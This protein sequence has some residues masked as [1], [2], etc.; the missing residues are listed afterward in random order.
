MPTSTPEPT[1]GPFRER[2]EA[3]YDRHG[4]WLPPLFFVAGFTWDSLTLRRIDAWVDNV[5]L[6]AYLIALGLMIT[7]T[8]MT[9]CGH[10][11]RAFIVKYKR[12]HPLAIQFFLGGLF[13]AYVVFYFKSASAMESYVFLSLLVLLLIANEFLERRLNTIELLLP[14][15]FLACSSFLTFFIPV[16]TKQVA[17]W[18]FVLANAVSLGIVL[19]MVVYFGKRSVF[20]SRKHF[21]AAGGIIL[22][23]YA[24]MH[25][26]YFKN[27][28]P[29]VPLA[30]TNAGVYHHA[31]RDPETGIYTLQY[32]PRAS[33]GFWVDYDRVFRYDADDTVYC[34]AAVFAPTDLEKD[35][36][37]HWQYFDDAQD[38]WM[39]TDRI[40]YR[41]VGGRDGGY[42][43]IS[44][45]RNIRPGKWRV[46]I[47]TQDE[48]TIGRVHFSA[49][50]SVTGAERLRTIER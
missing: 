50:A 48:K 15:Y 34:F 30:L 19:T 14:L 7:V 23:L 8:V 26:L 11:R 10:I 21:F 39:T 5:I 44:Y 22:L 33:Y 17:T 29:P 13:S 37:H 9:E 43:S 20:N 1:P 24:G 4:R 31:E 25:G 41:L 6:L 3:L 45:K 36:Y 12:W 16:A 47:R 35:V 46:E 49:V 38:K 28:I 40:P 42:R 2:L 27:W 18:T 32:E